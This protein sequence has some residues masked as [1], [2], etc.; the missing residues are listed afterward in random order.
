M[1]CASWSH[2]EDRIA[3]EIFN[4]WN[5]EYAVVLWRSLFM[6]EWQHEMLF[7]L[8]ILDFPQ[9]YEIYFAELESYR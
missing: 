9:K 2:V 5:F 8:I 1:I 4:S 3:V 6:G 7:Y